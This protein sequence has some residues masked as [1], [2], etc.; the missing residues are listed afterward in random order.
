MRAKPFTGGPAYLIGGVLRSPAMRRDEVPPRAGYGAGMPEMIST[1]PAAVSDSAERFLLAR[2]R[3]SSTGQEVRVS[4]HDPECPTVPEDGKVVISSG[5]WEVLDVP[6]AS[7][8][9]LVDEAEQ[10]GVA[11]L[12]DCR[13]CGG[14]PPANHAG[15]PGEQI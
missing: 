6:A 2:L 8:T 7:V 9:G 4:V 15:D 11:V 5:A 3:R 13:R 14:W 12:T 10:R 1:V